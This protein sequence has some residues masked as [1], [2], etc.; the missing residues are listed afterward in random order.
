MSKD[1]LTY[2]E[3]TILAQGYGIVA[4]SV[5][6]DKTVSLQ[7]KGLYSY[8]CTFANADHK[9][10]P[11]I[12]KIMNDL[13]ISRNSIFKYLKELKDKGYITTEQQQKNDG[14]YSTNVYNINLIPSTKNEDT[15]TQPSTKSRDTVEP[16]IKKRYTVVCDTKSTSS[17][18]KNTIYK[19][20]SMCKKKSIFRNY[21]QREYDAKKLEQMLLGE[22]DY[23]VE[24]CMIKS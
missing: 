18:N 19:N 15:D 14:T 7:A 1:K 6:T 16:S 13:G 23:S 10:W 20:T 2:G 24:E 9:A 12:E 17:F 11:G 3:G 5:M 4:K 21:T 8:L 22:A